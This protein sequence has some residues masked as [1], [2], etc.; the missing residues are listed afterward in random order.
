[1]FEENK[2][3]MFI[4]IVM[5]LIL[6]SIAIWYFFMKNIKEEEFVDFENLEINQEEN[7]NNEQVEEI[8]EIV[9]HISGEVVNQGVIS[10]NENSRVIDAINRAGGLTSKADISNVNLAYVLQDAQ[11]V[12]IP[13]VGEKEV[14]VYISAGSGDTEIVTNGGNSESEKEGK[15]MININTANVEELQQLAGIGN[16]TANKIVAYRKEN[17]KFNSIEDIKNVSGIGEAKFSKIKDSI[18]VK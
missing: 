10:L 9:V 3:K 4:I 11:K 13:S 5:C 16:S 2:K 14:D 7:I 17:G 15:L 1:M 12:Y 8:K 18:C 6:G